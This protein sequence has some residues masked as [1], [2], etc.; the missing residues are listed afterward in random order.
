MTLQILLNYSTGN[1]GFAVKPDSGMEGAGYQ[2]WIDC[3]I[4]WRQQW[5]RTIEKEIPALSA[6][7]R[8]GK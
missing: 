8:E 4:G 3:E 5:R 6:L 7:S 1:A 2:L